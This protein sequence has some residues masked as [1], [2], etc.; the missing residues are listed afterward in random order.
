[1]KLVRPHVL[2]H[3]RD[4]RF[5]Q[6]WWRD[7]ARGE[8]KVAL[9]SLGALLVL[10]TGFFGAQRLASEEEPATITTKRVVTI[11]RTSTRGGRTGDGRASVAPQVVTERE[12]VTQPARTD[13]VT[14]RDDARTVVVRRPAERVVVTNPRK[15]VTRVVT[16]PGHNRVVTRARTDTV[17]Q[18]ATADRAVTVTG[19]GETQTVRQDVTGPTVTRTHVETVTQPVTVTETHVE[20]ITQPVT[21]TVTN[22]LTITITIPGG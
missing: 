4:P 6:W 12:T 15:T 14:I 5:W 20:T 22:P 19:P 1:M 9:A 8:T 18:T 10:L 13:V 21:V 3:W 11:V 7:V 16:V 2:K 17:V